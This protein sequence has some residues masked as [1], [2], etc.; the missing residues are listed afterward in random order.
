MQIIRVIS[1]III[2]H[3]RNPPFL[4]T[5]SEYVQRVGR[6]LYG[7]WWTTKQGCLFIVVK[8]KDNNINGCLFMAV[9]FASY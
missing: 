7:Q 5:L 9:F 4:F 8:I 2:I 3:S 1:V 6:V